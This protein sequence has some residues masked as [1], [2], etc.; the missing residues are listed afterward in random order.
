VWTY[1]PPEELEIAAEVDEDGD[2][3]VDAAYSESLDERGYTLHDALTAVDGT[4]RSETSYDYDGGRLAGAER[5]DIETGT[6]VYVYTYADAE[7]A[8]PSRI[9]L[10]AYQSNGGDDYVAFV[11]AW[12]YAYDDAGRTIAVE[13][14]IDV[15][16]DGRAEVASAEAWSWTCP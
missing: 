11:A 1:A 9:R 6:W 13:H 14:E 10:T 2:G 7:A 4:L 8:A 16:A 15:A 3:A 12:D 5:F